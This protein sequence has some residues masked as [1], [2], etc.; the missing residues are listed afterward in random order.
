LRKPESLPMSQITDK[1]RSSRNKITDK[2]KPIATPVWRF[3]K[4]FS[5]WIIPILLI[6][7]IILPIILL[8]LRAN[9]R[10]DVFP[11]AVA[12]QKGDLVKSIK[13][14]ATVEPEYQYDVKVYQNAK[15]TELLVKKGDTVKKDQVLAR[16]DFI[17]GTKLRETDIINQINT[18]NQENKN[19]GGSAADAQR[20]SAATLNQLNTQIDNKNA[21][22][23][24]L[25][26][27]ITD[28]SSENITKRDRLAKERDD[29]QAQYNN[30]ESVKYIYDSIKSFNDELTTKRDQ[31][32]TFDVNSQTEK[33]K[34]Q[35]RQQQSAMDS[36]NAIR[37]SQ[38]C[39]LG[40]GLYNQVSCDQAN[41]N[42]ALAV[43]TKNDLETQLGLVKPV[44]GGSKTRLQADIADLEA[45]L[46]ALFATP[47]YNGAKTRN[48]P[49]NDQNYNAVIES[50]KADL[51]KEIESR[52]NDIRIIDD[53]VEI[54]NLNDQKTTLER[55]KSELEASKNT[56]NANLQQ[57][58]NNLARQ[59]ASNTTQSD[60]LAQ[61]LADTQADIKDQE[62]TKTLKAKKDGIVADILVDQDL[63]ITAGQTQFKVFSPDYRLKFKVSADTR[64]KLNQGLPVNIL[65]EAFKS[66]TNT[67]IDFASLTPVQTV[68]QNDTPEYEIFVNLPIT[69]GV[70]FVSGQSADV[71]IILNKLQNVLFVPRNAVENNQVYLG[72]DEG[73]SGLAKTYGRFEIRDVTTGLDAGANI[74]ITSGLSEG[75]KVFPVFPRT[76]EDKTKLQ[77]QF[78]K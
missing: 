51:K 39:L 21:D 62:D 49:Y 59:K 50:Q 40:S 60:N 5:G 37:S 53:S 18:N 29:L 22:I 54:D 1:L 63:E 45:K 23:S 24:D 11:D 38:I 32:A 28:K 6:I 19:L 56:Q 14:S 68:N 27:K 72:F 13:A 67:K 52:K 36:A 8:S 70:S 55:T 65:N 35:I 57:T 43:Q 75:E 42:Y 74:E 46:N 44:D 61:K 78:K 33:L 64:S 17:A 7:L 3:F 73:R 69:E 20:I 25:D 58:L 12:V 4:A 34:S 2:I 77:K 9:Q 31:L 16:I 47:E 71:E 30:L 76:E 48:P 10:D 66:I 26:K 15:I 41:A